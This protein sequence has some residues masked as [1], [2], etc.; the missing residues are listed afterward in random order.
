MGCWEE[1][2]KDT[3]DGL[4]GE[5]LLL[6]AAV[7]LPETILVRAITIARAVTIAIAVAIAIAITIAIAIASPIAVGEPGELGRLSR[8]IASAPRDKCCA[9][10]LGSA[11]QPGCSHP[12]RGSRGSELCF[13]ST[14]RV[15][16]P[17]R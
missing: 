10:K 1:K 3:G 4:A 9:G 6:G 14:Y 16:G 11:S 17:R 2:G 5:P 12:C 15:S 13:K 7:G 8:H